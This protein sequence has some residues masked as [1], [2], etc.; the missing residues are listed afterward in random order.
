MWSLIVQ[1]MAMLEHSHSEWMAFPVLYRE[2]LQLIDHGGILQQMNMYVQY[3]II[4]NFWKVE[5]SNI[6]C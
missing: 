4:G 6:H 3:H 5:F 1:I 2:W